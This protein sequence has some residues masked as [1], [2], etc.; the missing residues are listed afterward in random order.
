[1]NSA[2][3]RIGPRLDKVFSVFIAGAWGSSFGIARN[4]SEGGM[5]IETPEPYPLGGR[6]MVTF[7]FPGSDLEMT[8]VGEV[9]HICFIDR[10]AGGDI[11]EII[12]GMGV[13]F[14]GAVA[15][16][17]TARPAASLLIQ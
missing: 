7:S 1:M 14:V 17:D 6:M 3:R 13:R 5:F 12:G 10:T 4:I 16:E 2:N 11:R 15:S 9:V 8:V